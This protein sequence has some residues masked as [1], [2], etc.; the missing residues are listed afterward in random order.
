LALRN[1][2]DTRQQDLAAARSA[3]LYKMAPA[4]AVAPA[5]PRPRHVTAPTVAPPP[6]VFT[7]EVYKGDKKEE[8]KF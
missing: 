7:V 3:S 6:T 4:P 2:L 8:S 5:Q 1:P